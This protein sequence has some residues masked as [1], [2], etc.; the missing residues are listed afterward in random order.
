[1]RR[2][3]A[4]HRL[5]TAGR[6]FAAVLVAPASAEL[7]RINVT[8][9]P[10]RPAHDDRRR[11]PRD[12]GRASQIPGLPAPVQKI[13]DL[14]P[15]AD[16]RPPAPTGHARPATTSPSNRQ[17]PSSRRPPRPSR[18]RP[19][20][21]RGGAPTP[22]RGNKGGGDTSPASRTEQHPATSDADALDRE[23]PGPRRQPEAGRQER[24]RPR[25]RR[26]PRNADGSPTPLEQPDRLARHSPARRRSASRTSSSTSSASRP[27]CSR[28]TRPP[29]SSTASAGR[30]WR[31]STRSR[32][33]TGATST[34]RPPARSAGC[35]S[36]RRPGAPTASTP[37]A[38]GVADPY[39]PVDAIFAA[40]RYLR[41]AG[42]DQDIR[43]RDLRLQPRRLVRRLGAPARAGHRRPAVEPRRLAHRPD[44]GPL[45]VQAKATYAGEIK[46]RA[47]AGREGNAA[48]V[49]ESSTR[50]GIKIF[51]RAG[52]P[53]VAV[54]DGRIVGIG[55]N[56][57]LGRFIKLQ[58]VYGNTYTYAHLGKVADATPRRSRSRRRPRRRRARAAAARRQGADRPRP[59]TPRAR[60]QAAEA[61]G[62][63][64]APR[65][66]PAAAAAPTRSA[67]SP[68]RRART[69]RP[70]AAPSRSSSA[71]AHRRRDFEGYYDASSASTARTSSSSAAR[72]ARVVAGTIL[73]RIGKRDRRA[74]YLLFEIRPAGRGARAS[75]RSRSS[76]AGSCSSR[77]RSTAPRARTRSSAGRGEPVDRPDPADE[78]GGARPARAR[79]PERIEIYECGRQDIRAGADRPPRAGDARVPRR[80]RP[81]PDGDLA[82]LRPLLPTASG[83]VSQHSSGNAVDIAAINGIPISA[84]RARARSPSSRSSGCSRCRAR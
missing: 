66:T 83:N 58:D 62:S 16:P 29:A 57:R 44:P 76:T 56:K 31:R 53:V 49:V 9:V 64:T 26:P 19:A 39:N 3:Q 21:E 25:R 82:A 68:T 18:R 20:A 84:T 12:A 77:P 1:M 33:T 46:T 69:R 36:C 37:T 14:G 80:L 45:P 5:A 55:Q 11:P 10:A 27:S 15:V 59:P 67:C 40:A 71:P 7:H 52:A 24:R 42:A 6:L 60:R 41:A 51:S 4:A 70:P 78:Q 61:Q 34:S 32:P 13:V 8:L 54:N 38:T 72:G 48:M 28:S 63:P 17:T 73:G 79:Q 22:T 35:S 50:R 30:S 74:P 65:P 43:A 47:S 75:T 23:G 2:R 81:A